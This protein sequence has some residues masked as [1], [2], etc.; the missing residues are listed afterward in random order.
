MH[1][2]ARTRAGAQALGSIRR[3][4]GAVVAILGAG[5]G[6]SNGA[7]PSSLGQ[8]DAS[9]ADS[10]TPVTVSD[11]SKL[12]PYAVGH[13]NYMLSDSATYARSVIASVWYPADP[14]AVP[15][16]AQPAQYPRRMGQHASDVDV[17]GLGGARVRP[18]VRVDSAVG[19]RAISPRG[20]VA[21]LVV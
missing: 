4:T 6:G 12:G 3:L 18:R 16:S 8:A 9:A 21:G 20:G 15:A 2:G 5:C 1:E 7:A 19:S 13:A 11:P 17:D 14:A 10:G